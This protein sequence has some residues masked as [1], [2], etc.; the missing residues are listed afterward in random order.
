MAA[1]GKSKN[2]QH[3]ARLVAQA[4]KSAKYLALV[5]SISCYVMETAPPLGRH[6]WIPPLVLGRLLLGALVAKV[7]AQASAHELYLAQ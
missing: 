4:D 5:I 7:V 3:V 6:A 1:I 2:G